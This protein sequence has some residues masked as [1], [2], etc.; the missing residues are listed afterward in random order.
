VAGGLVAIGS[1]LAA[2]VHPWF[3]IVP[4]FFGSG[5]AFAGITDTCAMGMLL[6][7]MPWNRVA[8][9]T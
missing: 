3:W 9:Q 7:R 1:V 5:L 6:A 4:L 2:F 8:G